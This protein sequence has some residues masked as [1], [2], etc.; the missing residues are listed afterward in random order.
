MCRQ[1]VL[2]LVLAVLAEVGSPMLWVLAH[3]SLSL[4]RW[5]DHRRQV[6]V[7]VGV[8]RQDRRGLVAI[9]P[10]GVTRDVILV[11]PV[12]GATCTRQANACV[13]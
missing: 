7:P 2:V 6:I 4:A 10:W 3:W 5:V 11:V 9:G 8:L 13:L 12:P 1:L